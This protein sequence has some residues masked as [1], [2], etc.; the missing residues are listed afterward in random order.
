LAAQRWPT[1]CGSWRGCREPTADRPPPTAHR[2]CGHVAGRLWRRS[3]LGSSFLH[4]V[5]GCPVERSCARQPT[6][7]LSQ[8]TSSSALA[9]VRLRDPRVGCGG[10]A[11]SIGA[12]T[13]HSRSRAE[14]V[15]RKL[16]LEDGQG[17]ASAVPLL[18]D[19]DGTGR[20][21]RTLTWSQVQTGEECDGRP[22]RRTA[23][24]RDLQPQRG[25]LALSRMRHGAHSRATRR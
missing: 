5:N 14:Q 21:R 1:S 17:S 10:S 13:A 8:I 16:K 6:S 12:F 4:P 24:V 19:S 18:P 15:R 22:R 3:D 7:S 25:S 11:G 2:P 23:H 9:Q 20:R